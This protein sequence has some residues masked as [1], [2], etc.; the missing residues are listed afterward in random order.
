[1]PA[2]SPNTLAVFSRHSS[3]EEV[4]LY[5]QRWAT[6]PPHPSWF[7]VPKECAGKSLTAN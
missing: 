5:V 1:V 4:R 6:S 7:D 2:K 3:H